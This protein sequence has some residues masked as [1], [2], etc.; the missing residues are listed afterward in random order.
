MILA[1]VYTVNMIRK[2]YILS[3]KIA[4]LPTIKELTYFWMHWCII[5][6]F[7]I[8]WKLINYSFIII[9]PM[10]KSN[11]LFLFHF[12]IF[13]IYIQGYGLAR[14]IFLTTLAI[15]KKRQKPRKQQGPYL[16]ESSFFFFFTKRP[17]WPI[18]FFFFFHLALSPL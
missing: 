4:M 14:E 13:G 18:F 17:S 10:V 6:S 11:M 1:L 16:S 12:F 3:S 7:F 5:I 2:L 15:L 9:F 8:Y